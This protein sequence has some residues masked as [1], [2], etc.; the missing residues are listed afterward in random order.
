M[1]K[2]LSCPKGQNNLLAT[3]NES[4][5]KLILPHLRQVELERGRVLED[6]DRPVEMVYFPI[7]GV[8]SMVAIGRDGRRIEI[9]LFGREGMSG[10][11]V[12]SESDQ[13]P[14][15][16]FM[17]VGGH[18][19]AIRA[20]MLRD[21]MESSPSM[22]RHFLRFLHVLLTQ[23]S[24]TA[25]ANGHAKL[26]ERLSRWLLMCHDRIDGDEMELTHEFMSVMLGVR[27]AGVTVGTHIL[28]G[29]GLI[30][31]TRGRI[32]ILDREG[33]EAQAMQSYGIPEDEYDRLI[34]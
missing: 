17:Q 14:M 33:L 26:E 24:H 6:P 28:E 7:T 25:L 4:D 15:E 3:L 10:T 2:R 5:S 20:E 13:T 30:R 27:R 22:H 21:V 8:G 29:K 16:S 11:S 1:P 32:I 23:T 34:G 19:L 31:A 18:G 9:G 12:V